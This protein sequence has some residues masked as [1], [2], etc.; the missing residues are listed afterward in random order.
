MPVFTS[1][2]A[3]IGAATL[4]EALAAT[5]AVA[6]IAG[7]GASLLSG[8]PKLPEAQLGA[9]QARNARLDTGAAVSLGTA[10]D[11][12]DQRV[13]GARTG[14]TAMRSI[15]VLG[16]LGKGGSINI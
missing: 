4:G 9:R 3:A 10:G 11:V 2:A 5:A 8:S 7:A 12:A 15:D 6:G 16:G 14:N 13:S 1:I